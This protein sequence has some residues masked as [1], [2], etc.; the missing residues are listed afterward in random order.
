METFDGGARLLVRLIPRIDLKNLALP[1][2]Q[3]KRGF[4][5]GRGGPRPAQ[6][7]FDVATLMEASQNTADVETK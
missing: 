3:R 4:A 1:P 5:I 6:R 7:F 2:E